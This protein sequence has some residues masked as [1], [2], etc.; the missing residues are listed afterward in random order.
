MVEQI[1]YSIHYKRWH[2]GS[3]DEYDAQAKLYDHLL[4]DAIKRISKSAKI[5]DDGCGSGLL[6]HYLR[7]HFDSVERVDSS[8]QQV[9]SALVL[10]LPAKHLPLSDFAGWAD[11]HDDAYDAVFL[12]DVLEHVPIS[13]QIDFLRKLVGTMKHGAQL[14][15]KVPNANSLLASKWRYIDWTH[16]SSFTEC[17]LDF[18]CL[19][20]GLASIEY[21]DDETSLASRYPWLPRWGLRSFYLKKL[22]WAIWRICLKAEFGREA[23]TIR[24]GINLFARAIKT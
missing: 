15:L 2:N 17:S 1:D 23:D 8:V 14:Y 13:N 21:L 24:L 16:L 6:V 9:A 5:L 22:G 20:S 11:L 7:Q 18:V 3:P 10:K 19:S 12:F 4:H